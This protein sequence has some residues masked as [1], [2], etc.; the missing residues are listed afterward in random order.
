MDDGLM[1]IQV[2]KFL[3]FLKKVNA[4]LTE[5]VGFIARCAVTVIGFQLRA[6]L[7]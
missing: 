1:R 2:K 3:K 5:K 6:E 4:N 7:N